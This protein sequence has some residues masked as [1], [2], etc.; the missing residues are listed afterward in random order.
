MSAFLAAGQ[1]GRL[2]IAPAELEEIVPD[3]IERD[4]TCL[5]PLQGRCFC[6]AERFAAYREALGPRFIERVLPDQAANTDVPPFFAAHVPTPHSVVTVHLIDGEGE[7]TIQA[8][9]EIIDF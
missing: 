5:L 2:E 4:A 8:R 3:W 7:P 1:P 6:R 9:D